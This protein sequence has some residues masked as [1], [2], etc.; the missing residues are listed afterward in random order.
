MGCTR[1]NTELIRVHC[2]CCD[3]K[4]SPGTGTGASWAGQRLPELRRGPVVREFHEAFPAR[5]RDMRL[6]QQLAACLLFGR[7]KSVCRD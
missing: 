1:S 2:R 3:S 6:C 4:K 5:L 7:A